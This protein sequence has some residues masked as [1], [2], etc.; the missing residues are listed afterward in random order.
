LTEALWQRYVLTMLVHNPIH[1]QEYLSID[2]MVTK[3]ELLEDYK[4]YGKR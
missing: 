3:V 2:T 1:A 4:K